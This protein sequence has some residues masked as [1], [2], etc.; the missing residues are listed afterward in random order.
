MKLNKK[1]MASLLTGAIIMGSGIFTMQAE[2]ADNDK[3]TDARPGFHE[4]FGGH[5]DRGQK[6]KLSK[7]EIIKHMAKSSKLSEA[8]VKELFDQH[9]RPRDIMSAGLLA[10]E[11]GKNVNSILNMKKINN[12]WKEVAKSLGVDW[13]KVVKENF[14][15]KMPQK[16]HKDFKGAKTTK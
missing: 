13:N 9:Y 11:S 12:T 1:L 6:P 10:K 15:D 14:K 2:A 16:P 8:K 4:H 5:H 3:S 7:E